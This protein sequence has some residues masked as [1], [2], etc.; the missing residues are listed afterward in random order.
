MGWTRMV[1]MELD[2]EGKIDSGYSVGPDKK[3]SRP[4]Y[5]WGLRITL[6]GCELDKLGLDTD[7]DIGD[8]IDLRAFATVISISEDGNSRCVGL[9]I[10]KLAVEPESDSESPMED[11]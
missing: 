1:D 4:D 6:T 11:E 2:D 7:C 10:E 5:P 3:P 9:Q 8:V